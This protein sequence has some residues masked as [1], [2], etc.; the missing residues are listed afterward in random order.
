VL[1]AKDRAVIVARRD[2]FEKRLQ[3]LLRSGVKDGSLEPVD[4]T[5]IIFTFIGALHWIARWFKADGRLS[6]EKFG[7][8]LS[9][10]LM[11]GLVRRAQKPRMI[12]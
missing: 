2:T 9:D 12:K 4:P 7:R 11:R 5:V 6:E 1:H 8:Q 3:K 10:L